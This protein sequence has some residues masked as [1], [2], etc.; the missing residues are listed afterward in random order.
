MFDSLQ[1]LYLHDS[2]SHRSDPGLV[3]LLNHIELIELW[4][5]NN[6]LTGR[7]PSNFR[8]LT[9]LEDLRL[10]G[11]RVTGNLDALRGTFGV[12]IADAVRGFRGRSS[13]RISI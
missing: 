12:S 8:N 3:R 1:Y 10:E 4:L 11:T 6:P 2:G 9:E 13:G 5:H 7:L